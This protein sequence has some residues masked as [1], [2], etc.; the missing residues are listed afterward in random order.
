MIPATF[1]DSLL[2]YDEQLLLAVNGAWSP[3]MDHI[4]KF[5]SAV[6]VWFPLYLA[7]AVLCFFRRSY[8][9]QCGG[10]AVCR[11]IAQ[12]KFFWAGIAAIAAFILGYLLCDWGS[13]LV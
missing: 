3:A 4:M 5:L 10:Y 12:G 8:A 1:F 7:I 6:A 2:P 13:N 9:T 11:P